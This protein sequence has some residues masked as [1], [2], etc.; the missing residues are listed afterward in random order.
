MYVNISIDFI[1]QLKNSEMKK[2]LFLF[3]LAMSFAVSSMAAENETIKQGNKKVNSTC[4]E[5]TSSCGTQMVACCA[6]CSTA[7]L[8]A[9]LWMADGV[10][11]GQV[12]QP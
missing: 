10:F 1:I 8:F 2:L 6:S 11:C 9:A 7:D 3:L 4:L 12:E 5:A